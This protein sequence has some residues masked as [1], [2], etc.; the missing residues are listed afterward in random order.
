MKEEIKKQNKIVY[1][2][3]D[4]IENELSKGQIQALLEF[5]HQEVPSGKSNVS[6]LMA[7]FTNVYEHWPAIIS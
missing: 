3:K 4:L 6:S 5:N 1:K 2:Y 7:I